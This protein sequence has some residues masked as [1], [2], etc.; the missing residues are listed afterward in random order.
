LNQD[1][2]GMNTT[3]YT[4][5]VLEP[6]L[7]PLYIVYQKTLK[8]IKLLKLDCE[9]KLACENDSRVLVIVLIQRRSLFKLLKRS[10]RSWIGLLLINKLAA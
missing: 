9:F 3:K 4:T 2:L 6:H 8:A 1:K 7:V 10:G 5:E